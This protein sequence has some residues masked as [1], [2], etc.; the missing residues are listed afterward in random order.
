MHRDFPC[1]N[2]YNVKMQAGLDGNV[3]FTIQNTLDGVDLATGAEP[4]EVFRVD[5]NAVCDHVTGA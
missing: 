1:N 4:V 2:G 5:A 3:H